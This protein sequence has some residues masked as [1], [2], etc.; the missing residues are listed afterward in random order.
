M[1]KKH[2]PHKAQEA[3]VKTTPANVE[4]EE[5]NALLV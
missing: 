2:N 4:W 5:T 1:R 3:K